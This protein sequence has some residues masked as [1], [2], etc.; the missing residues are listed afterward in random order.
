[1][2][3]DSIKGREITENDNVQN[4]MNTSLEKNHKINKDV[5]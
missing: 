4:E 1:M 3:R 5:P 2:P